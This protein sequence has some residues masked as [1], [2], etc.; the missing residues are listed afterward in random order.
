MEGIDK[1]LVQLDGEQL[2]TRALRRL[3]GQVDAIAISS[4]ADPGDLPASDVPVLSDIVPD[5]AGPLA[6]VLA[7]LEW[8][9]G[10][11]ALVTVAVDTP[12][13]PDDLVSRLRAAPD[14]VLAIAR[15]RGRL[16]PV[17]AL[18][19]VR[20]GASLRAFLQRNETRRV[21]SFMEEAGF[22]L[23]DIDDNPAGDPFFN[24][25]TRA[26]LALARSREAS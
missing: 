4:N 10:F 26:D 3:R 17:F 20:L 15:S 12:F 7:G 8:A 18:W 6:G 1:S 23:V 5:H 25:N 13:F 19:P 9:A 24:I 16:H 21:M 2:V 11:D 14:G 22:H